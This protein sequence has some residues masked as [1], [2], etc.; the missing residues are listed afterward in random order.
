MRSTLLSTVALTFLSV[1]AF[2][3]DT[4][5]ARAPLTANLP[6][7]ARAV[8]IVPDVA[9][10]VMPGDHIDVL[11]SHNISQDIK[12][13]A[14]SSEGLYKS[15]RP[16]VNEVVA[17]NVQVLMVRETPPAVVVQ[18]NGEEAQKLALASRMGTLSVSMRSVK[19][20]TKNDV[21]LPTPLSSIPARIS[22]S[23]APAADASRMM[24]SAPRKK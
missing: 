24:H 23:E 17:A 7:G 9:L 11:L 22:A 16:A 15:L 4:A 1:N 14:Q 3:A 13:N 8:A 6:A 12:A 2:A 20:N 19:D 18:V 10:G 21:P 5:P